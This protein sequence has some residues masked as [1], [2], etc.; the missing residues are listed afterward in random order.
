VTKIKICGL[1]RPEDVETCRALGADYLGFNFSA[2]SVRRVDRVRLPALR[3]AARGALKVGIFVD[4]EPGAVLEAVDG[5]A[6]DILQV[7]RELVASDFDRGLPVISVVRLSDAWNG[8]PEGALLERCHALLFDTAHP[9]MAGGTGRPFDWSRIAGRRFP[10]PF[11]IAGGLAPENVGRAIRAAAPDFVDVASGVES[12]PG[13]KDP[14]R[15]AAFFE[16]VHA[17]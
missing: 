15:L 7:H 14:Q 11:G 3:E 17:A 2:R 4:E 6:L 13:V 8:V 1:T 10:V 16:A 5:M 9:G 12:S